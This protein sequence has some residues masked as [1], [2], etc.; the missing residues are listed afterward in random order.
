MTAGTEAYPYEPFSV[1]T[2]QALQARPCSLQDVRRHPGFDERSNRC[3]REL[4]RE[5]LGHGAIGAPSRRSRSR[6][7]V[8]IFSLP[9]TGASNSRSTTINGLRISLGCSSIMATISSSS[10][11]PRG[12]PSFLNEGL[13]HEKNS[14]TGRS[15][16]RRRSSSSEKRSWKKSRKVSSIS[17]CK[18]HALTPVQVPQPL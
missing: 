7:I 4:A 6:N 3:G 15:P 8:M 9:L 11:D 16:N 13:T 2:E 17:S 5:R 10:S 1:S 12:T 14:E 18:S